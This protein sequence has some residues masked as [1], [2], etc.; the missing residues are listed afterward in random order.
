MKHVWANR[1]I[2]ACTAS[3]TAGAAWPTEVTAMPEPRSISE[4]PSTSTRIAPDPSATYNG[5]VELT[6]EATAALRRA[7]RASDRGPGRSVTTFL[8]WAISTI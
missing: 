4:L 2:W 5:I 3:R 7:W 8:R 6:P 1:S